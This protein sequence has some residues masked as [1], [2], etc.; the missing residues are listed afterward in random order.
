MSQNRLLAKVSSL[1]PTFNITP[2]RALNNR[3]TDTHTDG[4]D[5]IPS[6]PDAGG[7]EN[8]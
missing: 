7:N 8:C 2:G 5:F 4:T 1:I 6:T 3:Q